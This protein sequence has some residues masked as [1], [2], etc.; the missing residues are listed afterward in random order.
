MSSA[1]RFSAFR[2]VSAAV[3]G[4]P[5]PGADGGPRRLHRGPGRHRPPRGAEPGRAS[6]RADRARQLG[7]DAR[8]A[9][10]PTTSATVRR[11]RRRRARWRATT[12]TSKLAQAKAALRAV[13]TAEPGQG[14]L[15]V[16]PLRPGA[17]R[18]SYGPD[19]N[20]RFLYTDLRERRHGMQQRRGNA[21]LITNSAGGATCARRRVRRRPISHGRLPATTVRPRA[22]HLYANQFFNGQRITIRAERLGLDAVVD[23]GD[24]RAEHDRAERARPLGRDPEPQQRRAERPALGHLRTLPVPWH[25]LEQSQT[26]FSALP[27]AAADSRASWAWRPARTTSRSTTSARTSIRELELNPTTGNIAGYTNQAVGGTP[28]RHAAAADAGHPRLGLHADRRDADR[29]QGHLQ[30]PVDGLDRG[31]GPQAAHVRHLPDGR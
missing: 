5:D 29:L 22:Y 12:P 30:R 23:A 17:Q 31:H 9:A 21:I 25:P 4:G 27:R 10:T 3:L 13:V 16:R 1:R 28:R 8:D 7:L 26:G 24:V 19:Q 15:P 2:L 18:P 6:Q 14:E 11:P 20:D